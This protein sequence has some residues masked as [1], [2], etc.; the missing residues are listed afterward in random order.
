[1][2]EYT[3]YDDDISFQKSVPSIETLDFVRGEKFNA[4][5]AG[6]VHVF[7]FCAKYYKG[8]QFVSDEMSELSEKYPNVAF[9]GICADAE[10]EQVEKFL[11][12]KV[13]CLNTGRELKNALPFFCFDANGTVRKLFSERLGGEAVSIPQGFIINQDGK[14]A[15]RQ[16]FSQNILISQTDFEKQLNHVVAGEPLESH[17]MKPKVEVGE[18]EEAEAD[19]MSLF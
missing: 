16:V 11:E 18:A 8:G 10:R 9:V 6:K 15:W 5:E 4:V 19:D 14:I 12:K 7:Y 17:G 2:S 3:T 1:M 13:T